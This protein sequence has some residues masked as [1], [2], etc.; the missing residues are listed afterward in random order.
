MLLR[1]DVLADCCINS[2]PIDGV[3]NL[4][5]LFSLFCQGVQAVGENFVLS[6]RSPVSR[7]PP[8]LQTPAEWVGQREAGIASLTMNACLLLDLG[9]L[10]SIVI[11]SAVCGGSHKTLNFWR[12]LRLLLDAL[13]AFAGSTGLRI[14]LAIDCFR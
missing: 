14:D 5:S 4:P 2:L 9:A 13:E 6:S 7:F 12:E 11:F 8:G 3:D 10:E 1:K